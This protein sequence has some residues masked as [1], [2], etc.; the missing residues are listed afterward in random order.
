GTAGNGIQ[1]LG[2]TDEPDG[3]PGVFETGPATWDGNPLPTNFNGIVY[4][5]QDIKISGTLCE[6]SLTIVS[7]D[8]IIVMDSIYT[9]PNKG[10]NCDYVNLLLMCKNAFIISKNAPKV[11]HI[12]AGII[13]RDSNWHPEDYTDYTDSDGSHGDGRGDPNPFSMDLD[14]DGAIGGYNYGGNPQTGGNF[15]QDHWNEVNVLDQQNGFDVWDLEIVGAIITHTGG[16]ASPWTTFAS[17]SYGGKE[18]R[19][20]NFDSDVL[21]CKP[22]ESPHAGKW[23]KVSWS[24][25][26]IR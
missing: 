22:P 13:S 21:L 10:C 8:N 25:E 16:S 26:I 11:L 17:S 2:E 18:T 15:N 24:E 1:E 14:R 23:R 5:T 9:C 6:G 7:E 20:Y 3:F 19:Y 12:D 4:C